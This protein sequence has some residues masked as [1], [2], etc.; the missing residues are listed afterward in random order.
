MKLLS[1]SSTTDSGA[2]RRSS[3]TST[4]IAALFEEHE[5]CDP[6]LVPLA[7]R[8]LYKF[9]LFDVNINMLYFVYETVVCY[10]KNSNVYIRKQAVITVCRLLTRIIHQMVEEEK[11]LQSHMVD[12]QQRLLTKENRQSHNQP[13]SPSPMHL[14]H[15]R[16]FPLSNAVS[17]SPEVP[18]SMRA[19]PSV[20]I[21]A[22]NFTDT[23]MS[24]ES[25]SATP[26][27]FG[28]GF[29][30]ACNSMHVQHCNGLHMALSS[31]HR[32]QR[33]LLSDILATL[34]S[35]AIA[36]SEGNHHK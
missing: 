31:Q 15:N 11:H 23:P 32:H 18:L 5:M 19:S 30:D 7:L 4:N 33:T 36:D 16:R 8:I 2:N 9:D 10:C 14:N 22:A 6:R 27:V 1:L 35:I 26:N 17:P 3:L 12:G 25:M 34:L 29:A 20:P 13:M 28:K 21:W 24:M